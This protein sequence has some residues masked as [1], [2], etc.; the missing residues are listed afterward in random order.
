[1]SGKIKGYPTMKTLATFLSFVLILTS[2]VQARPIPEAAPLVP[3]GELRDQVSAQTA[4]RASNIREVQTL[5][6]HQEVQERLGHLFE[7][8]KL[9]AAVP[10]MDDET[11]A[12]LARESK[13]M[14]EQFRAGSN[15]TYEYILLAV[16]VGI[17][18]AIILALIYH[19]Y[20]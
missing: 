9:A 7:L 18:V 1:M 19:Y 14:N 4:E 8:E 13:Q 20:G 17:G 5:L 15:T 6:R 11:L 12:R 16:G 10:K 3:I 2:I